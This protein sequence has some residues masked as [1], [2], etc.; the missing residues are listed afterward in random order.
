MDDEDL[1][2]KVLTYFQYQPSLSKGERTILETKHGVCTQDAI[3]GHLSTT[4]TGT[5]FK[6]DPVLQLAIRSQNMAN[7]LSQPTNMTLLLFDK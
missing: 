4:L 3:Q 1:W 2:H 7:T 5:K 6:Q